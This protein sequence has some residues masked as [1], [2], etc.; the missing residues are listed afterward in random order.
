MRYELV[1]EL[2]RSDAAREVFSVELSEIYSRPER[3]RKADRYTREIDKVDFYGKECL[4]TAAIVA[5]TLEERDYVIERVV[6]CL[7]GDDR[8]MIWTKKDGYYWAAKSAAERSDGQAIVFSR[9]AP[10]HV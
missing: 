6:F 9:E 3:L 7:T 5:T 1:R 10:I 8:Y 4:E 2:I